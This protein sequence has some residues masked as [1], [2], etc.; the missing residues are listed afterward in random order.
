MSTARRATLQ[1]PSGDGWIHAAWTEPP[2]VRGALLL[3]PP[4][5][6]EWQ[7]AYRLFALLVDAL[8]T[9]GIATLRF[10][11]RGSGDSSGDDAQFLPSRGIEDARQALQELARRSA[12]PAAVLAV[13]A[14]ALLAD[15]LPR[16]PGIRLWRWQPV[17]DGAGYLESLARRHRREC[18]NRLRY[19]FLGRDRE[20]DRGEL[21][22]QRIHPDLGAELG[23]LRLAGDAALR[24]DA[25]DAPL[26]PDVV[27]PGELSRWADEI[28]ISGPFPLPMVR[29]LA[30]RLAAEFDR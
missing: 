25:A 14:A 10:D 16:P 12:A 2:S 22:G 5:F 3:L 27:L 18:N 6:H 17:D 9:R 13:R 11:Y 23:A 26:P 1:L 28:D 7:R 24:I 4:L 29:A 30:D 8:A 15:R 21:M 19:P 20:P